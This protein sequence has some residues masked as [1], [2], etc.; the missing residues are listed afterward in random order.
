MKTPCAA[1]AILIG[2]STPFLT[3]NVAD[4]IVD[5]GL[6]EDDWSLTT[7]LTWASRYVPDGFPVGGDHPAWQPDV[8]IDTPLPG[9]S[10]RFWGSIQA[11]RAQKAFDEYDL[12]LTY[13]H[14]FCPASRFAVTADVASYLWGFPNSSITV[15]RYGNAIRPHD[16]MGQKTWVGFSLP[17][18]IPLGDSFLIPSYH[19]NYWL[20]LDGELFEPGGMHTL[21]L[22]YSH[23]LPV[24]IPGTKSQSVFIGG[25][26]NH[27]GGAFGVTPGWSHATMS[28]G[29]AADITD[30][31]NASISVT[32]QW[33][34]TESVN[35]EDVY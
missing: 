32:Y 34:F 28:T 4:R 1:L 20:P 13:S 10:I 14:G 24:F 31:L 33:S 22:D 16:M 17:K 12:I 30:T 15:N 35:P 2:V 6:N 11:E 18:L 7:T 29:A 8:R 19:Y 3:A 25:T 21:G 26:M 9:F 23:S 5:A 27:H